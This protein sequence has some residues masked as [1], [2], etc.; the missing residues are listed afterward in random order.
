MY[1]NKQDNQSLI[2]QES[3]IT[4]SND[5]KRTKLRGTL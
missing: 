1:L 2:R 5:E 3:S 4:G